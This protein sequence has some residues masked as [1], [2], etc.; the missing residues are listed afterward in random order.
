MS[1]SDGGAMLWAAPLELAGDNGSGVTFTHYGFVDATG[2]LVVPQRYDGYRY[3]TDRS[4]RTAFVIAS[5]GEQKNDIYD[6]SGNLLM[7]SPTPDTLCGGV[8]RVIIRHVIDAENGKVD[9]GLLNV[10]TRKVEV[11]IARNRHLTV[12]NPVTVN[13]SDPSG[14]YF[15]ELLNHARIP[16]PGFL[17]DQVTIGDDSPLLVTDRRRD[18]TTKDVK[19]GAIDLTGTWLLKPSLAEAT[20]FHNGFSVIPS[21]EQRTFMNTSM[22]ALGGTWDEIEEVS[23]DP[24]NV[25]VGYLVTRGAEH[26]LLGLE[27]STIISPG[28]A[29][30]SCANDTGVCAV[31]ESGATS[32]VQLP[33]SEAKPLP[34]GFTR[35]LSP[36]FFADA[37]PGD[38]QYSQRI[39]LAGSGSVVTLSASSECEAVANIWVAC[40]PAVG[41]AAPVVLNAAGQVT[42]FA[43]I[44]AVADPVPEAGT[45]YYWATS[46]GI[47]GFVDGDGTWRY[48]Q[49]RYTQLED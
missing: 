20:A 38:G 12:V 49:S 3:C 30:L 21:G 31:T 35:V 14:E 33:S 37:A 41:M 15:Y 7:Q 9:E 45:A 6:L 5:L 24:G 19:V 36:A 32:M 13:V 46:G 48:Q 8:D 39:Y 22:K 34:Q 44:A 17:D 23:S 42:A 27:L 40:V 29:D 11:P 4:G 28:L 1:A 26:G 16:H 10:V 47:E 43:S 18:L 25:V 2:K